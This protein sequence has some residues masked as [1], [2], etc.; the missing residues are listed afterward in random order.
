MSAIAKTKE[1][2]D[3]AN[4]LIHHYRYNLAGEQTGSDWSVARDIIVDLLHY[5]CRHEGASDNDMLDIAATVF[6]DENTAAI[7][8]EEKS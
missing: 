2:I 7:T 1:S 3:R 4:N 8:E 6:H 5:A